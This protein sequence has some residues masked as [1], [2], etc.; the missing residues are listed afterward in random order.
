VHALLQLQFGSG[1]LC[2]IVINLHLDLVAMAL[3][4]P[5]HAYRRR[6]QK[7]RPALATIAIASI[8]LASIGFSST[9]CIS[10]KSLV[11]TDKSDAARKLLTLKASDSSSTSTWAVDAEETPD[12]A[13]SSGFAAA[14]FAM[15]AAVVLVCGHASPSFADW[16]V[17]NQASTKP[18][19]PDKDPF[20]RSL[21]AKSWAMEPIFRQ[22]LYL[23]AVEQR[24]KNENPGFF[25]KKFFVHYSPDS[26]Y[27]DILDEGNFNEANKL[28]KLLTDSDLTDPT[29][30]LVVYLYATP[31]DQKWVAENIGVADY[32]EYPADLIQAID[33][34]KANPFVAEP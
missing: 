25:T 33:E 23:R 15:V 14:A 19:K 30:D 27:F 21:Q 16:G 20:I 17:R 34:L 13:G 24:V 4:S 18:P 31:K 26:K 12:G 8:A 9:W 32:V 11:H 7:C 10:N 22:R 28:G 6:K 2:T 5:R 1:V 29:S 3:T